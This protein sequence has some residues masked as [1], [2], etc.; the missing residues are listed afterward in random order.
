MRRFLYYLPEISGA[1]PKTLANLGLLDRFTAT[2]ANL[3]EHCVTAVNEG[4]AGHGCIVCVGTNPPAVSPE[5]KWAAAG[6]F[7]VAVEDLPPRPA[8]LERE[9]GITGPELT[10]ADGQAWR[11]PIIRR[12]NR[13]TAQHIS[14]LPTALK[15]IFDPQGKATMRREV[16][17]EY[18]SVDELAD[19]LFHDF[20]NQTTMPLDQAAADA[21]QLLSINYRIGLPEAGLLGLLNEENV[22]QIL[23]TSIDYAEI[24]AQAHEWAIE[25]VQAAEPKVNP[26]D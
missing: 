19:R 1:A 12:W 24:Q 10:L 7:W 22:V 25:G 18:Q 15:P 4:P 8:D 16:K 11:V 13:A 21:M 9:L 6:K 5:T 26:E 3:I 14:N 17:E 20:Y 2:G 23:G